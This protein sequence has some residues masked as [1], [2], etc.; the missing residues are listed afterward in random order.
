MN[1]SALSI[2]HPVPAVLLFILLT[3]FGIVGFHRLQIQQFPDMDQPT[4]N[5]SAALDGAAP[6]QLETEVARKIEDKLTSLRQLDHVTTTISEGAVNISV[7]FTID[8]DSNE[9]VQ[10]VRNAVDSARNE[11]PSA[12]QTPTVSK[13]TA[14][15][16]AMLTYTITSKTRGEEELSWFVDNDVTKALQSV[17]GVSSVTRIG[18]VQREVHVDLDP[19]LMGGLGVSA[20]DVSAK[21]K[22]ME[23]DHSGGQGEVGAGRQSLR[24]LGAVHDAQDLAAVSIPTAAGQMVR[25]DQIAAI[26]DS[27]LE[28][29]S[30]AFRDGREV[31]GFSVKRSLGFGD[32]AVAKQVRAAMQA[33]VAQHPDVQIVEASNTVTPIIDNYTGSMHL[34]VEGAVLAVIVVWCFLRDWRATLISATALPLSIIPTFGVMYLCGFSLN[35]VTLLSIALVIGILVDD[36]IVEVENIERHLRMGKTAYQ[37]AMEAA[38]EI[39]L[40]V[41]ATTLT[42]VAVFLPTAFMGGIPGKIF[43]E[44]GV[45]ASVA[46]LASLLVARLLTPMMAAYFLHATKHHD[47]DGAV[48]RRYLAAI[49]TTLRHRKTTVLLAGLFLVVS[50]TIAPLLPTGFMPAQDNAQTRVTLKLPP[51]STLEQTTE[52]TS[53]AARLIRQVPET[54]H[55]FADIGRG[56][57]GAGADATSTSDLGSATLTVDLAPRGERRLKQ[58]GVEQKI[59]EALQSLPGA[60]VNVGGSGNGEVLQI[61]LAS[62]DG[63]L[64]DRTAAKLEQ[65]IRGQLHGIGNVTSSA[66]LQ[67]PEIQIRPDSARAAALGVTSSDIGDALRLGTYGDYSASLPKLN[68]S[69]RQIDVRVRMDPALRA[70]PDAIGQLRVNGTK[71]QVALASLGD[72]GFG[73]GASEIDRIDRTR[74]VTLSVELNG[75]ALGEVMR[76]AMQLPTLR[77]LP[78]GVKLVQQG[79]LQR[80]SELMGSFA[81]AMGIGIFCIYAVLALLFHDFL[82]PATILSALPLSLGGALFALLVGRMSFSMPAVIGLLMLMGI[83]TKNSIL[84]VEYAIMARR[85]RGLSRVAALIDA[86]HKRARP[87]VMTTV[88]MGAGMAPTAIG[89]GADPS[90]RQPM[91]VVVIGG[92]LTSTLLSLLVVPVIFTFVDDLEVRLRKMGASLLTHGSQAVDRK[93]PRRYM[94][95]TERG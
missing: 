56:T 65:E 83:V 71:G 92:L 42:L 10:E 62:D 28:R 51:G 21:L 82:Q 35:M 57:S 13:V 36:A 31:I 73:S 27:H 72:I 20:S 45:T 11:L 88:A 61:V 4:V 50:L 16:S 26:R 8:K 91:A 69:D 89:F 63:G 78:T 38:D 55:I 90:F 95:G 70:D 44:F 64:L 18:G 2:K 49:G 74:Q 6:E 84:L 30:R 9:A 48:K 52:A 7:S 94:S 60:R 77:S 14:S 3:V 80:S 59:R 22:A 47:R 53:Q 46:V 23:S 75:R 1:V 24:T 39:G 40:A 25:L 81:L 93:A 33:F 19:A 54:R 34:L 37:A 58:S 12:L 29:S 66:S 67:R 15:N 43:R 17:A 86:C 79:E 5:I 87:I 68:L 76:E 32:A 41:I 85:S